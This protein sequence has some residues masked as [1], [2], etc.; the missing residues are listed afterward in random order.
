SGVRLAQLA[1]DLAVGTGR[2][3]R[4]LEQ[5]LP[6]APLERRRAHVQR[7]VEVRQRPGQMAPHLLGP[8]GEGGVVAR[9]R[10]GGELAPQLGLEGGVLV[11]EVDGADA[12]V[13]AGEQ[14]PTA[15]SAPST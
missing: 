12:A 2:A 5:L 15:A 3:A 13:G 9:P 7:Q 4:D 6:D 8:P 10:R 1:G 11:A 14:E